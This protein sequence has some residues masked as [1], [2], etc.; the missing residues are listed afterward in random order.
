[1]N[2]SA[3]SSMAVP[4][5]ILFGLIILAKAM[6]AAGGLGGKLPVVA[7]PLTTERESQ[8]IA[9][10]EQAV[11]YARVHAQV[12]MGAILKTKSGLSNKER[13]STRGRF[14]QKMVDYVLE[15]RHTG[16]ILALVE[17]DDRSHN[18]A[19]D[20]ARDAMT[21]TADTLTIRLPATE[22]PT[23]LGVRE[24]I[25]TALSVARHDELAAPSA[26]ASHFQKRPRRRAA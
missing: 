12:C 19:K 20:A 8:V 16:R 17:L 24:R 15:D 11:P 22:R 9:T 7:K 10:I 2:L 18:A 21:R 6:M 1:M 13:M 26:R 14:S 5:I 25:L 4:I 23:S 3:L